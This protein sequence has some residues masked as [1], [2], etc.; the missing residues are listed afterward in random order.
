M[1]TLQQ[2]RAQGFTLKPVDEVQMY[3]ELIGGRNDTQRQWL[4]ENKPQ[5]RR[6]LLDERRQW[7]LSLATE[8]GIHPDVVGAEFPTADDRQDVIEPPEHDDETLR[9]C[10]ATICTDVRVRQRQ[11]DY[12]AGTWVS[13]N[14]DGEMM[15]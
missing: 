14:S 11:Q 7:F 15:P 13:V 8:H 5:K 10:M 3:I 6:Q 12:V 2:I 9:A 1:S 4:I